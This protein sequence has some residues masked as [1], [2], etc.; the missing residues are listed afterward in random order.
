LIRAGNARSWLVGNS[1][2]SVG[3]GMGAAIGAA[4]A[5]PD[6]PVVLFTGDGGFTMAAQD[7]D[8]VPMNDLELTIVIIND[9]QYGSEMHHLEQYELPMDVIRQP[10]PDVSLLAEAYGGTGTVIESASQLGSF[11]FVRGGLQIVD[12]RVDPEVNVRRVPDA[13][14][15]GAEEA[16]PTIG[17][18]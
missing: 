2:Q 11:E 14:A 6:R 5:Y 7:L 15:R 13:W 18:H 10:I 1:F 12:V 16:A 4:T 9:Q 17:R 3:Q 8:A